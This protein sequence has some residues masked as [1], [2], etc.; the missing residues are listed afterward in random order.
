MKARQDALKASADTLNSLVMV[1]NGMAIN[2]NLA[3]ADYHQ[4]GEPLQQEF[5]EGQYVNQNGR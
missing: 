2:M 5:Q 3:V 4:T 1:I